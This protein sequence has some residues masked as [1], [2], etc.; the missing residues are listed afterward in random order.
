MFTDIETQ[1]YV[2]PTIFCFLPLPLSF[3]MKI[4]TISSTVSCVESIRGCHLRGH[5][6]GSWS[7]RVSEP[8]PGVLG[9]VHS[10]WEQVRICTNLS[11]FRQTTSVER[12]FSFPCFIDSK[13]V[14]KK[15]VGVVSILSN[16][17]LLSSF[18]TPGS[19]PLNPFF[20][21]SPFGTPTCF[22]QEGVGEGVLLSVLWP[23]RLPETVVRDL[24]T[25]AP[26][27]LR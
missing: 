3:I 10:R 20:V 12:G 17:R 6:L 16:K 8:D 24:L 15:T 13:H 26:V 14:V 19:G 9:G 25:P 5:D 21:K 11:F 4:I 22:L 2:T 18:P 1:I 27:F 23:L 7:V